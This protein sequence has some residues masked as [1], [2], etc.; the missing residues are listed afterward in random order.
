VTVGFHPK[1]WYHWMMGESAQFSK[2]Q[3]WAML[4]RVE[5]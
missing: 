5:K 2:K 1:S 4:D 3:W